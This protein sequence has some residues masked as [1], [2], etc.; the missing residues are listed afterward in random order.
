VDMVSSLDVTARDV[1][2]C[3]SCGLA[4]DQYLNQCRAACLF[5]KTSPS[6]VGMTLIN[7]R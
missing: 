7:P 6:F 1:T 3:L 4:M 5:K 2:P